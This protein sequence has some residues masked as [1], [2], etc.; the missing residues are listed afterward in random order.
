MRKVTVFKQEIPP[1][2]RPGERIVPKLVERGWAWFHGFGIDFEELNGGV[3][4]YT[5]AV[6][7][8]PDGTIESIPL[9]LAKFQEPVIEQ[10]IRVYTT[11]LPCVG[12]DP[13][14]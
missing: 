11:D 2:T 7:E 1:R 6:V 4:N 14:A 3:A 5:T 9:P 12:K 13:L 8:F 10:E